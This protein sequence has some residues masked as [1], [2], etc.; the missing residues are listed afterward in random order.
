MVWLEPAFTVG[1]LLMITLNEHDE[2]P[3]L[4]VAV[5]VTTVVP[6]PNVEPDAGEQ[7]TEAAGVPDAPGVI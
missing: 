4:F 3:Q 7:T 6:D 5:Q 1:E 2:L